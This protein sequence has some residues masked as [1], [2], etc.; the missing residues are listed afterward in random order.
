MKDNSKA[1][2]RRTISVLS[3]LLIFSLIGLAGHCV[4]GAQQGERIQQL[5]IDLAQARKAPEAR[6]QIEQLTRENNSVRSELA[7]VKSQLEDLRCQI[8]GDADRSLQA[9]L[10]DDPSVGEVVALVD[11]HFGQDPTY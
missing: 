11:E 5:E 3:I 10:S 4:T 9:Q 1:R 6:A 8:Q 2:A 7:I